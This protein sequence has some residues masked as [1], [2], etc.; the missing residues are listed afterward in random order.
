MAIGVKKTEQL[1]SLKRF[2]VCDRNYFFYFDR[3]R[4]AVG[5]Q[6]G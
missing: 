4:C 3:L 6:G 1:D 5:N 2:R